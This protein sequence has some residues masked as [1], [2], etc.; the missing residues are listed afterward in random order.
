[1]IIDTHAHLTYKGLREDTEQ[2]VARAL[3]AG[4]G[5]IITVGIGVEDSEQAVATAHRFDN[6]WAT[7]G[8][9][10]H[11]AASFDD[12]ALARLYELAKDPKV[13]GWGE[14][15]LD[16]FR[17]WCPV[18]AQKK[19]FCAQA[20][21]AR[22]LDLPLV[23]H[24]REAHEDVLSVLRKEA[25]LGLRG[26]VHCFS[27]DVAFAREVSGWAFTSRYPAPSPTRKTRC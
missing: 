1:M 12:A 20:A 19:A 7:V 25:A 22:R 9:H 5:R 26:V 27:G 4:V 23:V 11:D 3:E 14:T 8:V 15:G 24:D 2:I 21:A 18:D 17:D 10:P 13:V 6:V 16:Y